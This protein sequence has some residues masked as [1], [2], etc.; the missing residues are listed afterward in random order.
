MARSR[1]IKPS[2]FENEY[3]A[4]LNPLARLL[5]IGLWGHADKEGRLEDRPKKLKAVILP[6]DECNIDEYLQSLHDSGFIVRY[7]ID[8]TNYIQVVNF[9]KHQ[10]PH[11]KE[12]A[13]QIPPPPVDDIVVESYGNYTASNGNTETSKPFPSIPSLSSFPSIPSLSSSS[14][15][16]EKTDNDNESNRGIENVNE[17]KENANDTAQIVDEPSEDETKT[18]NA[19][20]MSIGTR[21]V[22]WAEKHWGRLI[23]PG[24]AETIISWSDEF[25][26]RGSPDPDAV[27]IEALKYC[28][29]ANA[30]NMHYLRAVL[31]DWREAGVLTVDHVLGRE[32]ERKNQKAHNRNKD[33][34]DKPPEPPKPGKYEAFY[35]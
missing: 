15:G 25:L 16:Q 17:F 13:S 2:F 28:L 27:V 35:L 34:G 19:S 6:Y 24:D 11:P 21:A 10:K 29:D 12:A 23:P 3:L 4:E 31:T 26:S 32:A 22:D 5:F 20:I 9:A 18:G 1:N 33:P 30:R 14:S 7:S 8:E